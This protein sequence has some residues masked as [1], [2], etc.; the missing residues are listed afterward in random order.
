MIPAKTYEVVGGTQ[1]AAQITRSAHEEFAVTG[2]DL[3]DL[4]VL[5]VRL[6][7]RMCDGDEL[8]DWQN[9]INLILSKAVAL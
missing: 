7:Y 8:R 6:N 5:G 9:R 1:V 3:N 2:T 4:A